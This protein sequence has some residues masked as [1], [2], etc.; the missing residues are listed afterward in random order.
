LACSHGRAW[1]PRTTRSASSCSA[2]LHSSRSQSDSRPAHPKQECLSCCL[3]LTHE[4]RPPGGRIIG[5]G[6]GVGGRHHHHNEPQPGERS[7][8]RVACW[9]QPRLGAFQLAQW[10]VA[11]LVEAAKNT[12]CSLHW[13]SAK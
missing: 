1:K 12:K 7:T 9:P 2:H 8:T 3:L 4:M 5:G 6:G 10:L 13:A 11:Q